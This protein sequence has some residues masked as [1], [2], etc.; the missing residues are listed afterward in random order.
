MTIV[1]DEGNLFKHLGYPSELL[2]SN[3]KEKMNV[4]H[5]QRFPLVLL[6][7]LSMQ[8]VNASTATPFNGFYAGVTAGAVRNTLKGELAAASL[9]FKSRNSNHITGFLYGL[10]AGYGRNLNGFYLGAEIGIQSDTTNKSKVYRYDIVGNDAEMKAKYQRGPVLS[11]APRLGVAF[12]GSYI[13]YFKPAL[14]ISKDK[15]I[16]SSEDGDT[17]SSK[18]K[19]K[20]AFVPTVGLEKAFSNNILVRVEYAYNLGSKAKVIDDNNASHSV[21]YTLQ[22]VK[23]GVAFQF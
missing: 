3:R 1:T 17:E 23:V 14:E 12:S 4:K 19:L 7:I 2:L 10:M 6:T 13:A 16:A 20:Y 8:S 9:T 21:K 22:A 18:K 15:T 11:I 5:L